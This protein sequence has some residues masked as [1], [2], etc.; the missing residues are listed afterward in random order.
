M[1]QLVREWTKQP[2][3]PS[4][5]KWLADM[6]IANERIVAVVPIDHITIREPGS[7]NDTTTIAKAL[8]VVDTEKF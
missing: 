2:N 4:L 3:Q 6:A 8:V 1:H 7:M 5:T